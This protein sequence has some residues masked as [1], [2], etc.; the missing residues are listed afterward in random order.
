MNPGECPYGCKAKIA[1]RVLCAHD[2]VN[3]LARLAA[4]CRRSDATLACLRTML[5]VVATAISEVDRNCRTC[6]NGVAFVTAALEAILASKEL[7]IHLIPVLFNTCDSI[8][9]MCVGSQL[10]GP[11]VW[12][13]RLRFAAKCMR[14]PVL[15]TKLFGTRSLIDVC[16]NAILK[17]TQPQ[18]SSAPSWLSFQYV[19]DV[20]SVKCAGFLDDL[21]NGR[22]HIQ[23]VRRLQPLMD[24]LVGAHAF[25]IE[26]LRQLWACN[27]PDN[28]ETDNAVYCDRIADVLR[29]SDAQLTQR[30]RED[31]IRQSVR[32]LLFVAPTGAQEPEAT[33]SSAEPAGSQNEAGDTVDDG[34]NSPMIVVEPAPAYPPDFTSEVASLLE[35]RFLGKL[36]SFPD[37]LPPSISHF[38]TVITEQSSIVAHQ[39]TL[40]SCFAGLLDGTPDVPPEVIARNAETCDATAVV[41]GCQPA[42]K[43]RSNAA[44]FLTE[45]IQRLLFARLSDAEVRLNCYEDLLTMALNRVAA[46]GGSATKYL[47]LLI[48][49]LR[50]VETLPLLLPAVTAV[51]DRCSIVD[52]LTNDLIPD[53]ALPPNTFPF[54]DRLC[55]IGKAALHVACTID[56]LSLL[57]RVCHGAGGAVVAAKRD[58]FLH[59]VA[60]LCLPGSGTP[61][62]EEHVRG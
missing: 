54:P 56:T 36:V 23:V 4:C 35:Q 48:G 14:A 50:G 37:T 31:V 6:G 51:N 16:R 47:H 17:H 58:L 15:E 10:P 5:T 9:T 20:L 32:S 61:F 30:S 43:F 2:S 7:D 18:F 59:W 3:I 41:Y 52:V 53:C 44:I 19:W 12:Q 25:T 24:V 42:N 27:H 62:E 38:L 49:L 8:L 22:L 55:A 13:Y 26:H 40:L 33:A 28:H 34:D 45:L 21:F 60:D 11:I 46:G 39:R 29:A 1:S 57:W